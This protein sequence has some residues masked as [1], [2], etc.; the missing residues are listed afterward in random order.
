MGEDISLS[1]GT[2]GKN[3]KSESEEEFEDVVFFSWRNPEKVTLTYFSGSLR[4]QGE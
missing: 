2:E 1:L 3:E 4:G